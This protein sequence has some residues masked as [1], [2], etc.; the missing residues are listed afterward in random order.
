MDDTSGSEL[1]GVVWAELDF[2]FGRPLVKLSVG[3]ESR[4]SY[5]RS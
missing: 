3:S 4:R 1:G 5:K 2:L